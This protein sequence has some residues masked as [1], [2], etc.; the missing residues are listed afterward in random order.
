MDIKAVIFDLD[1]TLFN[2]IQ[3]IAVSNNL[4]LEKN[5]LPTHTV[6]SYLN[7]I[8]NGALKLVVESLPKNIQKSDSEVLN[9]YLSEYS[10]FY[11]QNIAIKS[12]LYDG[13]DRVLNFLTENSIPMAINTNKPHNLT[14]Q[15]VE[16]YLSKWNFNSIIGQQSGVEKKPNPQSALQI[17][18]E[19]DINPK[20][21]LFVGDSEVDL[22]TGKNAGMLTMGVTWGYDNI[23]NNTDFNIVVDKTSEIIDFI[24]TNIS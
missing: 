9:K 10:E 24:K 4:M 17:A 14:M 2:S 20:D 6:G 7:W 23:S 12:S 15:V 5:N 13:I 22:N 18:Q 3:D 19:L 1:G 16:H 8:G 11:A 21:I